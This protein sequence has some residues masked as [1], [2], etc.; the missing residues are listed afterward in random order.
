M[1]FLITNSRLTPISGSLNHLKRVTSD[2]FRPWISVL[3]AWWWWGTHE[4]R[5][6]TCDAQQWVDSL[7]CQT[8]SNIT[9]PKNPPSLSLSV[10]VYIY[11]YRPNRPNLFKSL[12]SRSETMSPS[13]LRSGSEN[14]QWSHPWSLECPAVVVARVA[15]SCSS[16][17]SPSAGAAPQTPS[18]PTQ[19]RGTCQMGRWGFGE[20]PSQNL[21]Q[22]V[23]HH[24]NLQTQ[25][26][27]MTSVMQNSQSNI[28]QGYLLNGPIRAF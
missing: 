12:K 18:G 22:A 15:S 13:S 14:G 3:P 4:C 16:T 23:V 24:T 9:P 5:S 27:F 2:V 28:C 21:K 26:H 25:L 17:A 11:I 19:Q 8:S 20:I 7:P 10:S 6:T 1:T